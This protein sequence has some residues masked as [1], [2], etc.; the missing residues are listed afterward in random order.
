[1]YRNQFWLF[2]LSLNVTIPKSFV[3]DQWI[4]THV[5]GSSALRQVSTKIPG[6]LN[7]QV[8]I[9][10]I[11]VFKLMYIINKNMQVRYKSVP[12]LSA[13]YCWE[14]GGFVFSN[15]SEWKEVFHSWGNFYITKVPELRELSSLNICLKL[16]KR[17]IFPFVPERDGS[18]FSYRHTPT[19]LGELY[20][21]SKST[22]K[23]KTVVVV[24]CKSKFIYY[25][26]G[27]RRKFT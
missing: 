10:V 4:V 20:L 24:V 14:V 11:V 13:N 21:L 18:M 9:F 27:L 17:K 2:G 1:M 23:L 15:K 5:S 3:L 22:H 12:L 6:V 19:A 8:L 26:W 16:W 25:R 7:S